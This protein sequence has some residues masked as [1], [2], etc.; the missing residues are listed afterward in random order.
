MN[1]ISTIQLVVFV[2]F[3]VLGAATAQPVSAQGYRY[4]IESN[5]FYG[6]LSNLQLAPNHPIPSQPSARASARAGA[7]YRTYRYGY[8]AGFTPYRTYRHPYYAY[9]AF[10]YGYGYRTYGTQ[11]NVYPGGIIQTYRGPLFYPYRGF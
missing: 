8:P 10:K 9:P 1:R 7:R 6:G 3:A 2:G 11:L 4:G 5:G